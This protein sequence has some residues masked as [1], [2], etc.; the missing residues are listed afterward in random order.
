ML[1]GNLND[2]GDYY[3]CLGINEVI[4]QIE[5]Q[6]KYCTIT[7]PLDQNPITIPE[8]PVL[9]ELPELPEI[10]WP[11]PDNNTVNIAENYRRLQEYVHAITGSGEPVDSK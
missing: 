5:F 9:P 7:I 3:Q 4:D 2:F 6:G 1:T 11:Q 8:L 10:P